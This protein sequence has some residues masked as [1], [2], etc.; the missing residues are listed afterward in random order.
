MKTMQLSNLHGVRIAS[1]NNSNV[2]EA[3]CL[4]SGI[5]ILSVVSTN[6]TKDTFKL[7]KP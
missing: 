4:A 1:V 5:Y 2:M 3:S 7:L 6:G